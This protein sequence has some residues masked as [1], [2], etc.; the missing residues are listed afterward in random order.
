[1]TSRQPPGPMTWEAFF[2][3]TKSIYWPSLAPVSRVERWPGHSGEGE[4]LVPDDIWQAALMVYPSPEAWLENP[5]PQL[6]HRTPLQALA[7]GQGDEVRACIMAVAD[8]MLADPSEVRPWDEET[9]GDG[10]SVVDEADEGGGS[11]A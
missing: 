5:I 11:G 6:R 7:R 8:F 1:M 3:R 4:P 10:L 2:S 9:L